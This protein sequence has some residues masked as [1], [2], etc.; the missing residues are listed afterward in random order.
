MTC[1]VALIGV[2]GACRSLVN[3]LQ[4]T[5]HK[6]HNTISHLKSTTDVSVKACHFGI[7]KD[8]AI[9]GT[10]EDNTW[11][12]GNKASPLSSPEKLNDLPTKLAAKVVEM[13]TSIHAGEEADTKGNTMADVK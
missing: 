12:D 4:T 1:T 10:A 3:N 2:N 6:L 5:N 13:V 9:T 8:S 7:G 11:T